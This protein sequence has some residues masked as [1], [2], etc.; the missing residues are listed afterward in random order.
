MLC[1]ASYRYVTLVPPKGSPHPPNTFTMIVETLTGTCGDR[2]NGT[3]ITAAQKLSFHLQGP[4]ASTQQVVL[5]C[6]SESAVFVK[7][8]SV[9]VVDGVLSLTMQPDMI[10]TATTLLTNGAKGSH[11]EPPPSSRF[12]KSHTDNFT[13]YTVD[14]LARGFSDVYG[15]FAVRPTSSATPGQMAL[16]QVATARPT[17]WAPTN[18][19]PLTFM[20][21]LPSTHYILLSFPQVSYHLNI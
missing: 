21:T 4:L 6:S 2:C 5:W 7:Q 15:S 3:P 20:G 8:P 12:P 9:A 11:P 18:L 16:T 10:C 17:G 19:D 13:T 14:S 1:S